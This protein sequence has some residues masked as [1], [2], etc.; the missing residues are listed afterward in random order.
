MKVL[1]LG[2]G[3]R[4]DAFAWKLS[5]ESQIEKIYVSPGHDGMSRFEKVETIGSF[6]HEELRDFAKEKK[7]DL[8]IVGPETP[9]TM[10]IV[11][12]FI[13]SGLRIF[14]PSK[15]AA[16]L[17]GSKIF[18]KNFMKKYEIP[19]ASFETYDNYKDAVAGL[20]NWPI[21]EK[22][23][24]IKADGL[25]GGKGVVVTHDRS[26]AEHTIND[27]MINPEISVKSDTI[28]FENILPGDEVSV[29]ALC[30]GLDS[31][32]L[33]SACDHKR[34]GDNDTGPNTGGMGCFRDPSWPDLNLLNKI[35]ERILKP[36]LQ[37]C[38]AEGMSYNGFLFMGLMIDEKSDPY[39]V[40][41]NVRLGDPETQTLLPLL[42]GSLGQ[43]IYD[44]IDS[45]S[46]DG[47]SLKDEAS[48]H[49]VATSG[50]YPSLDDSPLDL[51]HSIDLGNVQDGIFL[52]GIKND[53]N[54]NG[55]LNSGGRVL[56]VTV[57]SST[58]DEA[59]EKAYRLMENI[60]FKGMHYR[61]DI[62]R[63]KRGETNG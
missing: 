57:S 51:G 58:V 53:E 35:E 55:Y 46:A 30:K 22:G 13:D 38:M 18:S 16:Q 31:F 15:K 19:T 47:L 56:G 32:Y 49:I 41:Y 25:A 48:V 45:G 7:I 5:N 1:I 40:E 60:K 42:D 2:S 33:G 6:S 11:D 52:A 24:V 10:G 9:L 27:F 43:F 63:R 4:E 17:E 44:F 12:L 50:G 21:E 37:G 26:E 28:L 39:V 36:T 23:I 8:T 14:G 34:L 3:G 62:A 59:R 20:S 61:S 54:G 29:F